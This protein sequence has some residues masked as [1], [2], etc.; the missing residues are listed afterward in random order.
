MNGAELAARVQANRPGLRVL[1]MSGYSAGALPDG[2]PLLQKP[3][4]PAKLAR[5]VRDTL[6]AG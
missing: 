2:A 4:S 3:F 1:F 5:S 6:D